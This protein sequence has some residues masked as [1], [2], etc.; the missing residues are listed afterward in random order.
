MPLILTKVSFTKV[1]NYDIRLKVWGKK[2]SN[3][4][5]WSI[6]DIDILHLKMLDINVEYVGTNPKIHLQNLIY[7][8]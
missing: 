7:K 8:N 1:D 5:Y 3:H 4:V 6:V 2:I